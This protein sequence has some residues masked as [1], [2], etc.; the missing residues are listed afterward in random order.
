MKKAKIII[1]IILFNII[2][3]STLYSQTHSGTYKG[4]LKIVYQSKN[5]DQN[6]KEKGILVI[7][8]DYFEFTTYNCKYSGNV[9]FESYYKSN[10]IILELEQIKKPGQVFTKGD[11]SNVVERSYYFNNKYSVFFTKRKMIIG[12][13]Y[14]GFVINGELVN[15]Y[16]LRFKGRRI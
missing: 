13:V 9:S 8:D 6:S 1:T 4:T 14:I 16:Q 5:I 2:S 11:G 12:Q 15:K 7:E 10:F 3:M